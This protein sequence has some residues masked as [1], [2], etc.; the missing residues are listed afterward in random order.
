MFHIALLSL[1]AKISGI[2]RVSMPRVLS[3]FGIWTQRSAS[4]RK[5]LSRSNDGLRRVAFL[6]P[7]HDSAEHVELIE[8]G[9]SSAMT[10]SRHQ[11]HPAPLRDLHCSAVC[12]R[13]RLVVVQ[14]IER[15]EPGVAVSMEEEDLSTI[16]G[17]CRQISRG[18]FNQG[19]GGMQG[20]L[21]DIDRRS[22][23]DTD[24]RDRESQERAVPEPAR[25][26]R[27]RCRIE[28]LGTP[29]CRRRS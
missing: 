15:R 25:F 20:L 2:V 4:A 24:R 16:P 19:I 11:E 5:C 3:M 21:V 28:S 29:A 23:S 26:P 27:Y 22:R 1:T 10:H 12:C 18:R 13:K 17:K 9:P 6:D 7:L 14:R 8:R